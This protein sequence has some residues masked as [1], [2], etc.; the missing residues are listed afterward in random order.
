[1]Q[2]Q[3][4]FALLFTSG[5]IAV[6]NP[7]D[8]RITYAIRPSSY[9]PTDPARIH[10]KPEEFPWPDLIGEGSGYKGTTPKTW[11][12]PID[13]E[14]LIKIWI[15]DRGSIYTRD[16]TKFDNYDQCIAHC[17]KYGTILTSQ[18]DQPNP[19]KCKYHCNYQALLALLAE[20]GAIGPNGKRLIS[21][22]ILRSLMESPRDSLGPN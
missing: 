2:I 14:G 6:V 12:Y 8:A 5:A 18:V 4:F 20:S 13:P 16:S 22:R 9:I 7:I 21:R 1:M 11:Y 19:E 17:C 10:Q 15:D 3:A